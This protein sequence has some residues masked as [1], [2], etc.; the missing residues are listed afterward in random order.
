MELK[1]GELI[2]ALE[3]LQER[4]EGIRDK[5][6]I[7]ANQFASVPHLACKPMLNEHATPFA[8]ELLQVQPRNIICKSI[9]RLPRP[10]FEVLT[11][12][13]AERRSVV[14]RLREEH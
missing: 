14:G 5:N 2:R 1:V 10:L 7:L 12:T 11:G 4:E 9:T 13:S 3:L 6:V 8:V